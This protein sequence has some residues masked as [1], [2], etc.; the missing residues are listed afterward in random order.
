MV[1]FYDNREVYYRGQKF[2][3]VCSQNLNARD[4]VFGKYNAITLFYKFLEDKFREYFKD[5]GVK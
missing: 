4:I 1:P 3:W 2:H 5:M